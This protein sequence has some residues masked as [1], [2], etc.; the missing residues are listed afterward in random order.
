MHGN[1][2][3]HRNPGS[4]CPV[5]SLAVS[6]TPRIKRREKAREKPGKPETKKAIVHRSQLTRSVA[7]AAAVLERHTIIVRFMS[8]VSLNCGKPDGNLMLLPSKRW[9]PGSRSIRRDALRLSCEAALYRQAEYRSR[10]RNAGHPLRSGLICNKWQV[11]CPPA[12]QLVLTSSA[13]AVTAKKPSPGYDFIHQIE[14]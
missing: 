14:R 12:L 10:G 13:A 2:T 6:I 7:T 9:S 3:V 4:R 11:I 5:E 1:L 8:P